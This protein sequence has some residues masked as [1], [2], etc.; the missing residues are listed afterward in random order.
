MSSSYD[1][2]N[3]PVFTTLKG[4]PT[5]CNHSDEQSVIFQTYVIDTKGISMLLVKTCTAPGC[6]KSQ[7]FPDPTAGK[8][9]S[10]IEKKML[11][12]GSECAESYKNSLGQ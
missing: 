9:D 11:W 5:I 2:L 8:L 6:G 12:V 3:S 1:P 4:Y 10:I 7:H